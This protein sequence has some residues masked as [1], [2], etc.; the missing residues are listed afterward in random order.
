[1]EKIVYIA[2]HS[3]YLS[4]PII[5]IDVSLCYLFLVSKY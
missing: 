1:M 4:E 5:L 2:I 3:V